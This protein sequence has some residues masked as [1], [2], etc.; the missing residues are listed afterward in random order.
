MKKLTLLMACLAV[1]MLA[2]AQN[3]QQDYYKNQYTKLYKNYVKNPSNVVNLVQMAE[4]YANQD[5]QMFSLPMAMKYITSAEQNYIAIIEDNS[6]YAEA[7]SA[8]KKG[9]TISSVRQQ[10]QYIV[11]AARQFVAKNDSISNVELDNYASAFASDPGTMR[12]IESQ[13]MKASFNSAVKMN[14][15]EAYLQF[16]K[17]YP[18]TNEADEAGRAIE[19]LASSAFRTAT[20]EEEVDA[21]LEPYKHIEAACKAATRQKAHIV[22]LEA[23]KVNT[24]KAYR[25]YMVL[26]PS[27]DDYALAL[28]RVSGLMESQYSQMSS[29]EEL[30]D[31]VAYNGDN[32]LSDQAME[33]L[34]SM[35]LENQDVNA[36]K[37]Y[38]DRFTLDP[39]Y[40]DV[41]RQYY[42]WCA[43]EGDEQPIRDFQKKNPAFPFQQAIQEDLKYA[44]VAKTLDLKAEFTEPQFQNYVS[45][46]RRMTGK[47]LAFVALQRMMQPLI[48]QQNWSKCLERMDY[49]MLSFDEFDV[50][51]YQELRTIISAKSDPLRQMVTEVTPTYNMVR[52]IMHPDG[53]HIYFTKGVEGNSSIW[54]AEAVSGRSYKWKSEGEVVFSNAEN[55]NVQ[56]Y[57]LYDDGKK[58]LFGKNGDIFMAEKVGNSWRVDSK[59]VAGVNTNYIETD[60]YMLPD[61]SGMLLASDRPCGHDFH[62]S[63]SNFHGDTA[64]ALDIYY[65]PHT[66][67]GWGKAVNLGLNVNSGYCDRSPVLSRDMKTLYFVTD[68]RGGLG[69]GDVYKTSRTSVSDWTQ[70]SKPVNLGKEVNSGACEDAVTITSDDKRLLISSNRKGGMYGCYSTSTQHAESTATLRGVM[71]DGDNLGPN[72][73]SLGVVDMTAHT[74][75]RQIDV[76]KSSS[77]LVKLYTDH[78][79]VVFAE[80]HGCW[81]PSI[82]FD[83]LEKTLVK[84]TGYHATQLVSQ[85]VLKMPLVTFEGANEQ[86][87]EFAEEDLH[88]LGRFL[89]ANDDI[90]IEVTTNVA[91]TDDMECYN[92]S[93]DRGKMIKKALVE[94]GAASG[95]VSV[96]SYGNINCKNDPSAAVVTVRFR[97]K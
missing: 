64:L 11:M 40:N 77:E 28:D 47:G 36:L 93:L 21:R 22:Y 39:S 7:R 6:R 89:M 73:R 72:L 84:P 14:T 63:R 50:D 37:I 92:K 12:V 52:P 82:E 71:V 91:G 9:V 17:T 32:P 45:Y 38:L 53:K 57:C 62:A 58:M 35:I 1:V 79:Y 5:N 46:V 97:N 34:R 86:L 87:T 25:D 43:Y 94:S 44:E 76:S 74:L 3:K 80:A 19:K 85:G 48:A 60:A 15:M 90:R 10:K 13:R 42:E 95:Q 2:Q 23:E 68:G 65:I 81:I 30:A 66:S 16:Q 49:V 41:Y 8:V 67:N 51:R 33:R 61:G 59:A 69:Y 55:R 31:F 18:G 70:W 75:T 29:A 88:R 4:F 26:Y 78:V 96:S 20:T 27:G 56:I 24:I 83:P 54:V